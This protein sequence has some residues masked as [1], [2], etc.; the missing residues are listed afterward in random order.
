M[1]NKKPIKDKWGWPINSYGHALQ[2]QKNRRNIR[3]VKSKNDVPEFE[4]ANMPMDKAEPDG[5]S[6]G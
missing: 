1:S 4:K 6:F 2:V 3:A 5:P